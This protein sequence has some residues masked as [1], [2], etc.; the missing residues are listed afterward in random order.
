M[1]SAPSNKMPSSLKFDPGLLRHTQACCSLAASKWTEFARP[2]RCTAACA[3]SAANHSISSQMDDGKS[4]WQDKSS[5]NATSSKPTC[6]R[7]RQTSEKKMAHSAG[8][9]TVPWNNIFK[10]SN[11]SDAAP[12]STTLAFR[13]SSQLLRTVTKYCGTPKR[14]NFSSNLSDRTR[15]KAPLTSTK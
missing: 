15:S 2:H 14:F 6:C 13:L 9:S 1:R 4:C 5:A 3:L 7:A 8:P 12:P 10:S 11:S